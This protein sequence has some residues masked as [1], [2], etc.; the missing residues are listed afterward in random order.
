MRFSRLFLRMK[1]ENQHFPQMTIIWHKI[2]RF[3]TT[4]SIWRQ[5]KIT[6]VS[7]RFVYHMSKLSPWGFGYVKID[8]HLL[9]EPSIDKQRELTISCA[10]NIP[11]WRVESKIIKNHFALDT[12]FQKNLA[13][14]FDEISNASSARRDFYINKYDFYMIN[15]KYLKIWFFKTFHLN[16]GPYWHYI[17]FQ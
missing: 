1:E 2:R 12:Y 10:L 16:S 13:A 15:I 4:K 17:K 6:N 11:R 9:L 14:R 3:H 5:N 8:Q 7:K